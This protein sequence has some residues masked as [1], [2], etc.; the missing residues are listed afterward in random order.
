[1]D[2]IFL[3]IDCGSASVKMALVNEDEKLVDSIYLRNRG[4]IETVQNGLEQIANDNYKVRG[5]GI[6]GSGRRFLNVM[7]GGDITKTEVISHVIGVLKY[8]PDA[9]VVSD[10]GGEDSKIMLLKDGVL[11]DFTLNQSCSSGTGSSLEAIATRMGVKI[12]DVGDMAL[13]SKR[14]LNISTKCGIFMTSEAINYL[15]SGAKKEDILWG[16]VKGM[17]SNYFSMAQDKN[18]QPP[19]IYTG[20][21]AKNIAIVK[22]FNK[23]LGYEIIVPKH[24]P[25]MGSIGIALIAKREKINQTNFKGFDISKKNYQTKN[26][27]SNRCENHCEIT[28]IFENNNY[29]GCLG[30]RCDNCI[31]KK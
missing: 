20:M 14:E 24:A 11:E 19:H 22:A 7:I 9:N 8:Y 18:L 5:V 4:L 31:T 13:K 26:Y 6:T 2:D 1:M 3:G 27:T 29:L 17:V 25:I 15:N 28:Q 16:V 23:Y 12:E 21:T 30:N 10:I